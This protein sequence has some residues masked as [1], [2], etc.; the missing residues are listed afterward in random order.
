M[1]TALRIEQRKLKEF[2]LV[3]CQLRNNHVY[4][5]NKL[6]VFKNNE[7]QLQLLQLSHDIFV[8]NYS[9]RIKI[10]EILNRHYY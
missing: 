2:L 6:L 8:A 4:Y 9:N 1:I 7:L 5:Q 10:Y 3:E